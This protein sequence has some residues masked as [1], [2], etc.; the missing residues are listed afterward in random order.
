MIQK[1]KKLIILVYSNLFQLITPTGTYIFQTE[2]AEDKE[3]I[4]SSIESILEDISTKNPEIKIER[5]IIKYKIDKMKKN[6]ENE[7]ERKY[8]ISI[9]KINSTENSMFPIEYLEKKNEKIMTTEK[10]EKYKK[11]NT[12]DL[13]KL[14]LGRTMFSYQNNSNVEDELSYKKGI[15]NNFQIFKEK[16]FI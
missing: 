9:N 11:E 2:K 13:S 15:I 12:K 1:V 16:L 14:G 6:K 5:A 8:S 4:T 10:L 7:K 3:L